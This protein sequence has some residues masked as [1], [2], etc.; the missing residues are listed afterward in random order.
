VR[1][2]ADVSVP[3]ERCRTCHESN[4]AA[5]REARAVKENCVSVVVC[6][7]AYQR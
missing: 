4:S 2:D 5:P 1:H 3:L 7:V 6:F